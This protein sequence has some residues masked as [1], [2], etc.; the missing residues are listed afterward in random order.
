MALGLEGQGGLGL[1]GAP[2]FKFE[3]GPHHSNVNGTA[4]DKPRGL[5]LF[6]APA[7][8][9]ELRPH[10]SNLNGAGPDGPRGLGLSGA[11]QHFRLHCTKYWSNKACSIRAC[12]SM[13]T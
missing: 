6:G 9:F 10:H 1:S 7:L 3:L 8:K 4:P 2:A 5:G 11:V 13:D 12:S